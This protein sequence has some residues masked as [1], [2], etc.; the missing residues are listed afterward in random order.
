MA[1]RHFVQIR[2]RELPNCYMCK[3]ATQPLNLSHGPPALSR[4]PRDVS[5]GNTPDG[6]PDVCV[7][8]RVIAH[9]SP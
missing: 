7:A 2:W 5:D 6:L 8:L 4:A 3:S 9:P 1:L